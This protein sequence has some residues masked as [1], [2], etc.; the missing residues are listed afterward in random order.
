MRNKNERVEFE[1]RILRYRDLARHFAHD[2]KVVERINALI[3]DLE[4]KQREIDE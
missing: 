3:E 2:R 1:M 4:K